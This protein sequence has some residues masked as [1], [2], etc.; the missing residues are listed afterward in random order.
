VE[1]GVIDDDVQR[2]GR[3][4]AVHDQAGERQADV[5]GRP[6]RPREEPVR[7]VVRPQRGQAR[8]HEHPAHGAPPG[9]RE[10]PDGERGTPGTTGR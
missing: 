5:L 3:D 7:P 8:A 9:R 6:D 4:E 10:H 1:Q 2:T